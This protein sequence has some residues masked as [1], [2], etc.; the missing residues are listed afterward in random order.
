MIFVSFRQLC[1]NGL[2]AGRAQTLEAAQ[3]MVA[4]QVF[5]N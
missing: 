3:F 5:G 1:K 2:D 4:L